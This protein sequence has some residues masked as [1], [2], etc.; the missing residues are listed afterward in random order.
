MG[1]IGTGA[2]VSGACLIPGPL[3][4]A[5]SA[6]LGKRWDL[7]KCLHKE[8]RTLFLV[9]LAVAM[10]LLPTWLRWTGAQRLQGRAGSLPEGWPG[11]LLPGQLAS[12]DNA[13]DAGV[14]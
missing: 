12:H 2:E 3:L 14:P 8:E 4:E 1:R 6:L 13:S 5:T 9:L 7:N 10:C 11:L